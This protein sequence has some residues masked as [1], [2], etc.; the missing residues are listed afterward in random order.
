VYPLL[1]SRFASYQ[2]GGRVFP[3]PSM[4]VFRNLKKD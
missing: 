2:S 3:N 1:Q 4:T